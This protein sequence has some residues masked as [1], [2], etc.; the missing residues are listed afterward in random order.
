[1]H[2]NSVIFA[3]NL[4]PPRTSHRSFEPFS[5]SAKVITC[6]QKKLQERYRNLAIAMSCGAPQVVKSPFQVLL[7]NLRISKNIS[8]LETKGKFWSIRLIFFRNRVFLF[9]KKIFFLLSVAF[10]CCYILSKMF[11]CLAKKNVL[12]S[13]SNQ[14]IRSKR[15]LFTSITNYWSLI[16]HAFHRNNR[17]IDISLNWGT[18]VTN[19]V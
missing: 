1:M 13:V 3:S 9:R 5:G 8:S 10:L 14:I 15:R 7:K 18:P 6:L 11:Q 12:A 17:N 16:K 2:W 19:V 4:K